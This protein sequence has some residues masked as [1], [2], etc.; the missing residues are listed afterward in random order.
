MEE[1]ICLD[2][3]NR[4]FRNRIHRIGERKYLKRQW[5]ITSFSELSKDM[6]LQRTLTRINKNRSSSRYIVVT[7]KVKRKILKV[8]RFGGLSSIKTIRLIA[9]SYQQPI[10]DISSWD[11][12]FNPLGIPWGPVVRTPCPYC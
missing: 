4:S 1:G 10:E 7:P 8:T 12:I 11:N 9:N 5:L 6:N 3:L 2:V